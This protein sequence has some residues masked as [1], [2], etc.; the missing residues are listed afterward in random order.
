MNDFLERTVG[1]LFLSPWALVLALLV[2]A[3]IWTRL[4]RGEPATTLSSGAIAGAGGDPLPATLRVRCAALPLVLEAFAVLLAVVALARPVHRSPLPL[5][6]EGIDILLCVDVS[7]SMDAQDLERGRSRLDAARDAAASFVAA[8]TRDRVGLVSFARWPDV[9]CPP[10][11][12]HRALLGFLESLRTVPGDGGEDATGIGTAVA[13]SAQ[14]LADSRARSKV[15]VLLT[16]G[17]ENV[18]TVKAKGEIAPS[19]AAQLCEQLGVRVHAVSVGADAQAVRSTIDTRPV[20]RLA[21]RTGG[22][23]F[24]ARDASSL[25]GVYAAIDEMERTP[26]D[27]P[28]HALEER[29][30]PFLVASLALFAASW[31]LRATVLRVSP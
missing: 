30:A 23:F 26:L 12:D 3:A 5:R 17:E 2:P 29:F 15:V 22:R 20:Q 10:T 11:L 1:I 4:C 25:G 6:A 13:R 27:E 19:H 31:T 16:D 9:K 14:A 24:R 8:R 21:E 7:S 28:R 18:A